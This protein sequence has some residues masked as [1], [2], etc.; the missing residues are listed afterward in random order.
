MGTKS[1]W[2]YKSVHTLGRWPINVCCFNLWQPLSK[3]TPMK[4]TSYI[5]SQII[6]TRMYRQLSVV[7]VKPKLRRIL[8]L[9]AVIPNNRLVISVSP[10]PPNEW[11]CFTWSVLLAYCHTQNSS[12]L[13]FCECKHFVCLVNWLLF[14]VRG[15]FDQRNFFPFTINCKSIYNY[16]QLNVTQPSQS[17]P[18]NFL[19]SVPRNKSEGWFD[20]FCKTGIFH[21]CDF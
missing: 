5:L 17:L 21:P 4:C 13:I 3:E 18:G 6:C 10:I 20:D 16:L 2:M 7:I 15:T 14:T 1:R 11:R 19:Y 12:L 9:T 8:T